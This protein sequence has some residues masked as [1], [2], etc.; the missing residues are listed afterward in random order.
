MAKHITLDTRKGI[1]HG[2]ECRLPFAQMAT[3]FGRAVSTIDNK[4]KNRML[5]TWRNGA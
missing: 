5:T 3:R 1:A 2:L 4:V